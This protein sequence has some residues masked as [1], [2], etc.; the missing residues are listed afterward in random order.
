MRNPGRASLVAVVAIVLTGAF[1]SAAGGWSGDFPAG[2]EGFHTYAEMS[3]DVAA[4]AAAHPSI[5]KRFSIG[6]SYQGRELWAAKVSDNVGVDENEPEVLFEGLHHGDEHMSLEMTLRILHWLAEGYGRDAYVTKLVDN[7][8]VWI[9]FAVN[10]DGATYDISGGSYRLWRKN[11]QPNA[12]SSYVG[13][14]LNRNY[15]YRW[16]C[17]GGASSDPASIKYRGAAPYSAPESRA[18]ANFI[19]SRVVGGRQQIRASIHFHTFGRL[20]MWPYGYTYTDLPTDM[21]VDDHRALVAIG[22]NMAASNG[23][24]PQQASDLYISSGTTRDWAYG[25]Y[26][27]F[28]YTFELTAVSYPDDATIASETGRNR[29]AVLYLIDMA[30]C[31]YGAIGLSATH[32]GPFHDDLEVGRGWQLDPYRTDTAVAGRWQRWNPEATALNGPKQLGT[33]TSGSV[34]LVTGAAASSSATANDLDGGVTTVA[35]PSVTLP[36]GGSYELRFRYYFAHDHLSTSADYLRVRLVGK[37][38]AT[39]FQQRATG[40]DRDA[41]W[42]AATVAIPAGFAGQSVRVVIDA[43]D[44]GTWTLVEAGVDDVA[45]VRG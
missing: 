5:V 30:H 42:A 1:P 8:E 19:D 18:V 22:R 43:A 36:A 44:G 21:T 20:V 34:D 3:A 13:T 24:M 31:P 14:D 45:I 40:A 32:C 29:S 10:P 9:I 17:C 28:S 23:Y 35:S 2:S 38:T 6:R 11:R 4:V 26:R 25:R 41:A 27:I 33:T 15:D 39:L 12:G 37:T 7:R 16:G